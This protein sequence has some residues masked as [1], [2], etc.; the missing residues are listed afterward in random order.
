MAE[1]K[2][3]FVLYC[4]LLGVVEKL[5]DDDAGKLMKHLLQYVNDLE[6]V[7]PSTLIDIVFEPIRQHLKRDLVRWSGICEKRKISGSKGGINSGKS[8]RSK[9]IKQVLKTRSKTKQRQANE[10]DN[11]N[12]NDNVNE[13][14][15]LSGFDLF[16]MSYPK[17]KSKGQAEKAW[18]KI[19][20]KNGLVEKML[21]KIESLRLSKDWIKDGGQFIP[22]P[23]TWL[24][25]KGWED[26][27]GAETSITET[28][29]ERLHRLM[30][31]D[32][33]LK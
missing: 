2:R 30:L 32:K 15:T 18:S 20:P 12:D 7:A 4:D 29:K 8:R 17:K 33:G 31:E 23:A 27:A 6:P 25:A 22:Y 14:N 21:A 24:N 1:G 5:S 11:D 28:Q 26:E 19:N 16:W 10:A 3:S 9:Q 13:I